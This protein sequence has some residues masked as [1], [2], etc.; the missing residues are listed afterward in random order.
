V[1]QR[2]QQPVPQAALL[3][4]LLALVLSRLMMVLVLMG[5]LAG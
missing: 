4:V 2:V 5:T 3:L 1:A